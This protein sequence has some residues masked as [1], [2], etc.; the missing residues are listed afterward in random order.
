[1]TVEVAVIVGKGFI[2]TVDVATPVQVPTDPVT[3]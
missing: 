3:V 1:M 2:D